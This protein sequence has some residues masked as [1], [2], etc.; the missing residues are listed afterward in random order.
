MRLRRDTGV[1]WV[2]RVTAAAGGSPVRKTLGP[3]VSILVVC[4]GA[5]SALCAT[6]LGLITAGE[7]GTYHQFGL[8]LKKLVRSAGINLTVYPSKGSVENIFAVFQRPGIQMG[9][10]QSDVLAFVGGVQS[11]PDLA[12]IAKSTRVVFPLFDEQV[13]VL[14]RAGIVDFDDLAGKR[15]AIGQEGSGTHLTANLL[16]K[17]A[18]VL[19]S[20]KVPVDSREALGQ[21][22][23]GRI[24]AMIYVAAYPVRLL[25]DQVTEADELALLPIWNKS[26][27]ESYAPLEIA[28]NVYGWQAKPVATVA[29]K[30]LLVSFDF[31]GRECDSIGRFAGQI[32]KGRDWLTRNGHPKWKSVELDVPVKGWEQ[33]DCVRKYVGSP[34]RTGSRRDEPDPLAEMVKEAF[35]N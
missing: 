14:A 32:A 9:I 27:L 12:R 1:P 23:A 19:P 18:E 15:V 5:V 34:A 21:L 11:N 2:A 6:D 20:Q 22:K 7:H 13:H 10:V 25:Q 35:G 4:F 30:A 29:V 16:F 24:D 26:I 28:A 33:S 31:R 8:D 17:L 3:C